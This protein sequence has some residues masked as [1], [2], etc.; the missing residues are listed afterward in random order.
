MSNF[1]QIYLITFFTGGFTSSVFVPVYLKSRGITIAHL[2]VFTAT[3]IISQ[4][5]S[6]LVSGTI[7][8]KTGRSKPVLMANIVIF[9]LISLVF[10]QMPHV[11]E[12]SR[13]RIRLRCSEGNLTARESCQILS[14]ST[15]SVSCSLVKS[16][17]SQGNGGPELCK[18]FNIS[19]F[20][21]VV[22][23]NKSRNYSI[24]CRYNIHLQNYSTKSVGLCKGE[25]K[26]FEMDCTFNESHDCN[27]NRGFWIVIYGILI[28]FLY[29]SHTTTY[30]LFDVIVTDLTNAHKADFGRQRVFSII[31]SL[32]GPP[33]AGYIL[34][35]SGDKQYSTVFF[36]S[37][38]FA[39]LSAL[40]MSAVDVKP[41]KPASKMW[42]KT[43]GWVMNLDVCL[44]F[45]MIVIM[46]S[47][48]GFQITYSSWYLQ[49]LGASDL[50][51]GINRGMAGL[52]GLPFL[53]SSRWWV[54]KIGHR[55]LFVL[56][57]LGHAVYCFSFS[58]LTEPWFVL[59]IQ[60]TI[61][62]TYHLFWV[63]TMLNIVETAPEGLQ[64]TARILAGC[65]HFSIGKII[66]ILIGGYIMS[67]SG[68]RLA[69]TV[70]GSI[71]SIYAA[72]YATHV[73]LRRKAEKSQTKSTQA[74]QQNELQASG[75]HSFSKT[76]DNCTPK[77]LMKSI[78]L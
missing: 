40:S 9:L 3:S 65:L 68:G 31:G 13:E 51:L 8:D 78:K 36:S 18:P 44:F 76:D 66:S 15:D 63:T 14:N 5:L 46:G 62:V 50:L 74:E 69:Y 27:A 42:K 33:M 10:T 64:A 61:V 45:L 35:Q 2:S 56:G 22:K 48:Y 60:L 58:L 53:Y 29:F 26:L 77:E 21:V 25:C 71:I 16:I 39:A 4:C 72:V 11:K 37:A 55:N 59:V 57:L 47:A 32:T 19:S 6:N 52:Y 67:T 24:T 73:V 17:N 43:L 38:I 30:R 49:D 1:V 54:D 7:T 41:K 34:H 70:M 12:C 23:E 28:N 75:L 20:N